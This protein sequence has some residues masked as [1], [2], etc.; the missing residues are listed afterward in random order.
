MFHWSLKLN[1]FDFAVKYK[2]GFTNIEADMLS[3]QPVLENS[4]HH[5][6]LFDL[7]EIRDKKV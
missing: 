6:H 7:N 3:R 5:I 1:M 2:K 4:L